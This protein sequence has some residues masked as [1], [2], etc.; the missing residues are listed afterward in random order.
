MK[1]IKA[2]YRLWAPYIRTDLFMY[3]IM[4]LIIIVGII[5]MSL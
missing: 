4:V 1:K 3:I 2:L 5:V